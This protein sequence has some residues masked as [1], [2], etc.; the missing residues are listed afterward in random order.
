MEEQT[1]PAPSLWE[2]SRQAAYA[3]IVETAMRLFMEQGFENTTIDQI[4]SA[5]G[6]SRRSFFRYFGTKEDIV[7][8]DLNELGHVVKAALEER[9]P[10]ES[11]WDALLA[12]MGALSGATGF[13][14]ER[15]FEIAKLTLDNPSLRARHIEKHLR[16]QEILVPEIEK[17]LGI[18]SGPVPDPRA[19]AIVGAALT[20]LDTAM[21]IWARQDGRGSL[22]DLYLQAVTAIR[23]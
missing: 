15:G 19:H 17:R 9:P 5:V 12:A 20:C 1:A 3:E 21:E 7:F 4:A 18:K 16:W 6:I 2:R 14:P 11:P 8:G 10:E 22:E 23:S 13:S